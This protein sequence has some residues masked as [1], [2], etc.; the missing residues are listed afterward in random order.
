MTGGLSCTLSL[1]IG[2]SVVVLLANQAVW[3]RLMGV[4]K[5]CLFVLDNEEMK[6][7]LLPFCVR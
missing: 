2:F 1:P 3:R 7:N 5:V 4:E 6:Y